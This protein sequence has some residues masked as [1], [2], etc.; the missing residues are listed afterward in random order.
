[1]SSLWQWPFRM[2]FSVL[3]H[4]VTLQVDASPLRIILLCD[5]IVT[6]VTLTLLM[7]AAFSAMFMSMSSRQTTFW[8]SGFV[9]PV[10]WP[11]FMFVCHTCEVLSK[12]PPYFFSGSPCKRNGGNPCKNNGRCEEDAFGNYHCSCEG[13]F[14]GTT[15]VLYVREWAQ[16]MHYESSGGLGSIPVHVRVVF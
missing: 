3:W 1:M 12:V 2:Q 15:S 11:V 13:R 14:T 5:C 4:V 16:Y 8:T 7:H 9:L 10:L 6:Q